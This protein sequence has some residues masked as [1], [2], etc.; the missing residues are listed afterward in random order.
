MGGMDW[1]ALPVVVELLGVR[2][3]DPLIHLLVAIRDW[4]AKQES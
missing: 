1:H 2:D 3:P 4:Q